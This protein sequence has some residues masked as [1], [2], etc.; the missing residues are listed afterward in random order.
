MDFACVPDTGEYA[1]EK[2]WS[3]LTFTKIA[4]PSLMTLLFMEMS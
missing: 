1:L 4:E 2:C 3:L